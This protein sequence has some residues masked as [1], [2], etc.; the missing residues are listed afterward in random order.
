M[1]ARDYVAEHHAIYRVVIG[2]L[3]CMRCNGA[4]S[5]SEVEVA[6]NAAVTVDRVCRS[7]KRCSRQVGTDGS[8]ESDGPSGVWPGNV[9]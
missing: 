2:Q 3:H 8:V 7:M 4:G 6:S 5:V 1:D 9:T